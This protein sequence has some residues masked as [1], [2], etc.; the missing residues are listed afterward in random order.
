VPG[1][2]FL[3]VTTFYPPHS[4]GGD[5]IAIQRLARG[6]VKAGHQVTVIHDLDAFNLLGGRVAPVTPASLTDGVEVIA[7]KSGWGALAPV[8]TH[9]LGRPLLNRRRITDILHRGNFDVINYHNISL[10]G[11]PDI[12]A[13]GSALK[14]YIAH[15]HWLV[16]PMHVLWRHRRELCTGKQCFRCS[17]HYRR[18]PQLYRWTGLME[19]GLKHVDTFIALSEFSR[20]K[21][22]EFGFSRELEVLPDFAPTS[23]HAAEKVSDQRPYSAPYFLIAGRLE[24]IKG[25]QDVIPLFHS[26]RDA[27]LLIAG[28][29]SY[30]ST[31]EALSSGNDRVKFLGNLS[32]AELRSL[33]SHAIAVVAPSL[34][35]E[36][37]GLVVIEV[38]RESTPVIARRIGP[39]PELI[40]SSQAGVLF[41][42]QS[43]LLE[44]MRRLQNDPEARNRLG[45]AGHRA[46]LE[47]WS[48]EVV[49]PKYLG[50]VRK[51]ALKREQMAIVEAL[52]GLREQA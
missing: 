33:Y 25:I 14:L 30:R 40:E 28:E 29:G 3:F 50:I 18:P 7:L 10:I 24:E 17:L 8:V 38:F 32:E 16:C 31:L 9:Q 46:F 48:E 47:R 5:A 13:Y 20:R 4:F 42:N 39:F 27:H 45:R 1:L 43:E 23:D 19:R 12:L 35:F 2:R 52:G 11:G 15:D 6:L 49:I 41:D 51:T 22:R 21:H 34:C 44:A 37:F 26:Y 36:T